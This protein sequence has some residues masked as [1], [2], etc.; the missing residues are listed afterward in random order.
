MS[1]K[2]VPSTRTRCK[3]PKIICNNLLATGYCTSGVFCNH[4]HLPELMT[5]FNSNFQSSNNNYIS[6]LNLSPTD[7]S[8][9]WYISKDNN[10]NDKE[11]LSMIVNCYNNIVHRNKML[12]DDNEY[13]FN[14]ITKKKRLPIFYELSKQK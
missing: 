9:N 4:K 10:I 6:N 14:P 11:A 13:K 7:I 8:F 2:Y 12:T 3:P 5:Y 1:Y